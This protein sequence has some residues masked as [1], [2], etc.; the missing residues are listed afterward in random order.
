MDAPVQ[1]SF[2]LPRSI[3][4]RIYLHLTVKSKAIVLFLTTASLEDAA[5][6]SPLGS[7]VY[8]LPDKYNPSQ[9]LATALCTVEP[10][11]EFTTRLAKLLARKTQR[12]VYVGN[13]IS[14][15]STG[16]GGTVE[17][18]LDA[19]KRVV[20]VTLAQLRPVIEAQA[21]QT[22]SDGVRPGQ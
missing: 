2:P 17:E 21:A 19:F 8:A 6:P 15:A 1:L 3:D 9:P 16:L 13:S 18:E 12:P 4:T 20:E 7:F 11:I 22:A 14:L 5:S 10:T